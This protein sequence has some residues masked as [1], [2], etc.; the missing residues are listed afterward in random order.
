MNAKTPIRE[1]LARTGNTQE[2]LAK[3]VGLT[4]GAIS[5]IVV[6]NRREVFVVE[7]EGTIHLEE[8]R[9]IGSAA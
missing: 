9:K 3:M 7:S 6:S 5:H 4:Q 2:R 8:I 1:W